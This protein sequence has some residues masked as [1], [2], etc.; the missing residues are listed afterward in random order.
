[1]TLA[2]DRLKP[3]H[4]LL[5]SVN[6]SERKL[7]SPR[8]DTS[9]PTSSAKEPEKS[10][11]LLPQ[12]SPIR[13]LTGRCRANILKRAGSRRKS[14]I[15]YLN[16]KRYSKIFKSEIHSLVIL[17]KVNRLFNGAHSPEEGLIS[18][19]DFVILRGSTAE[20]CLILWAL[21]RPWRERGC[22]CETAAGI[23]GLR[24]TYLTPTEDD[25]PFS[26]SKID[27]AIHNLKN[28]KAP[29]PDGLYG[30]VIKEAYAV[31]PRFFQALFNR[32]LA[33][34]YFPV[35]WKKAQVVM[36]NNKNKLDTDPLAYRPI[37]L[38]DALGKVLDKLVNNR[39]FFHLQSNGHL[40]PN[41]FGFTPGRS[42]PDAIL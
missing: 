35:K 34:G 9:S 13:T 25:P 19:I 14:K 30:D 33:N 28:K 41:Q 1:M 10:Q 3:A 42:A 38:L 4:L 12:K 5:D 16:L 26:A 39:T 7:D 18:S 31:N 20:T 22:L 6:S 37:C 21:R 32:C 8:L 2:I 40:H 24:L 15:F 23:E 36:F 29:G 27:A 17:R 11:L